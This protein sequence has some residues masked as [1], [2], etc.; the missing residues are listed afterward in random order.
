[1]NTKIF[2]ELFLVTLVLAACVNDLASRKIP[3]RLILCGLFCAGMLHLAS[4]TPFNLITVG[5]SGFVVGLLV[6]FPLYF[7]RGM[8]AGDVK[9]MAMVGAFTGPV[10]AFQ[11]ALA[12]FCIGGVMALA[13]VIVKGRGRELLANLRALLRPFYMRLVGMPYAKEA[14][15]PASVGGMP[16]G[17]AIAGATCLVLWFHQT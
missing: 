7:V 3:N 1:M 13:I 8:A 12:A 2:L 16:Y 17:V 14:V 6:F 4:R 9:L 11:I 15:R 5:L 10:A